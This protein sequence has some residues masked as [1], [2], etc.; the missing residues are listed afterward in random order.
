MSTTASDVTHRR[1][2]LVDDDQMVLQTSRALVSS[3]G[4]ETVVAPGVAFG[5]RY[6]RAPC[7]RTSACSCCVQ[8]RH[9]AARE[10]CESHA[11]AHA[12]RACAAAPEDH[13]CALSHS[14]GARAA[15]A[16]LPPPRELQPGRLPP[17]RHRPPRIAQARP[18]SH[19]A[20]HAQPA[21][22]H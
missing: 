22:R 8:V 10:S 13:A 16:A 14:R 21:R 12:S 7:P 17:E 3:L 20:A 2:L 18:P 5:G 19:P 1:I 4:Y 6:R 9:A 15:H 11:G